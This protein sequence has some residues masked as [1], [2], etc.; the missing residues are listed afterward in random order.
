M[1]VTS[2]NCSMP[3]TTGNN[4]SGTVSS[5]FF[6]SAVSPSVSPR[7]AYLAVIPSYVSSASPSAI[8]RRSNSPCSVASVAAWTR[9][10]PTN[11][12]FR[13]SHTS[14]A[15]GFVATESSMSSGNAPSSNVR[16]VLSFLAFT[17]ASPGATAS[18]TV[19]TSR[20]ACALIAQPV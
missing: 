20:M 7:F 1:V 15:V 12:T 4:R 11:L 8:F 2:Q 13:E 6:T 9:S 18:H 17:A 19:C 5:S 16:A 14:L 10:A 3:A